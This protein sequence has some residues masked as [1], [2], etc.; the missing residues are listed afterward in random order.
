MDR[1]TSNRPMS[2]GKIAEV[3]EAFN[4][5]NDFT[6]FLTLEDGEKIDVGREFDTKYSPKVGGY[7]V[8]YLDGHKMYSDA[9]HFEANHQKL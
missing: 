8:V 5:A 2:A 6:V 4:D 3:S 1:Y 7:Y 9:E